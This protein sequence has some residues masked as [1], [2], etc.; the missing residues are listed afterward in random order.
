MFPPDPKTGERKFD[1][2]D[3]GAW[4]PASAGE[5]ADLWADLLAEAEAR[6]AAHPTPP[7]SD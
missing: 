7:P 2:T 5:M 6:E 3:A 4:V 1:E